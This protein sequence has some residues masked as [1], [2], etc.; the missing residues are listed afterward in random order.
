[1]DGEPGDPEVLVTPIDPGVCAG[2]MVLAEVDVEGWVWTGKRE[3]RRFPVNLVG[4]PLKLS[5][6]ESTERG[7]GEEDILNMFG[8]VGFGFAVEM[9]RW[10]GSRPV[11]CGRWVTGDLLKEDENQSYEHE[12]ATHWLN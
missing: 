9:L 8:D 10:E 7:Q 6:S 5:F 11:T 3:E 1:M 12:N 4:P 2:R